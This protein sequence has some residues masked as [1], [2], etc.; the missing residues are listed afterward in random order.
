MEVP[1]GTLPF[2]MWMWGPTAASSSHES[3]G[4]QTAANPVVTKMQCGYLVAELYHH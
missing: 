2:A 4:P 3:D 1:P